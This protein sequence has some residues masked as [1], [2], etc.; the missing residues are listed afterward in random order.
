MEIMKLRNIVVACALL[1]AMMLSSCY[2]FLEED[3]KTQQV[4]DQF[5]RTR[6]D[7]IAGL[8]AVYI[9]GVRNLL[10]AD[11]GTG[12]TPTVP[13]YTGLMSGLFLDRRHDRDFTSHAE[14]GNFTL[15]TMTG[16]AG[17]IWNQLY[18]GVNRASLAIEQIPRM[19]GIFSPDEINN[20]VAQAKFFRALNFFEL[21]KN[22]G[23]I[24]VFEVPFTNP[25]ETFMPRS[26]AIEAYQLIERDL[27]AAIPALPNTTFYQNG[28]RV[29][30]AMA[31]TLLAR[32]YLQWAGFP[33]NGGNEM[34]AK[35]AAMAQQ[36]ITG[37]SGHALIHSAGTTTGLNSAFNLIREAKAGTP[38][39]VEV[40][41]AAEFNLALGFTQSWFRRAV[42]TA[43]TNLPHI[44]ST[45]AYSG[46]VPT[47][48]LMESFHPD[49][50]RGM[51]QQ[52]FFT[53]L[54]TSVGDRFELGEV[55]NWFWFDYNA[56]RTNVGSSQNIPLMRFAEVL[57]IAAEGLARTGNEAAAKGYLNQ[58]RTR[59]G[60]PANTDSGN[61]LIQ[62]ILTERLHE[63][64]LEFLIWDDIRRTRLYPQASTVP[65]RLNWVSLSTAVIQ[66]KPAPGINTVG[67]LPEWVLLWPIPLPQMS[68]NPAFEGQQN[69]GWE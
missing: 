65:G 14:R 11:L 68:A 33:M 31:Q 51:N 46:F 45:N 27:L 64:P 32:V 48:M 42:P 5:W 8:H 62:A 4:M 39:A 49:D 29:T 23:D 26:P 10:N 3:P 50:I 21:V 61:D 18:V 52:F 28:G 58:V 20:M 34:Y 13:M 69:P 17:Q 47:P 38:G 22:F 6:E 63:F 15:L 9:A 25:A 66:N 59:A 54:Y 12:W 44:A 41:Y 37:G 55:G 36:V 30:R 67:L 57:L 43:M 53:Y 35:A 19:T 60:L 56:L 24:P 16:A 40:I 1:G 2:G 7:G